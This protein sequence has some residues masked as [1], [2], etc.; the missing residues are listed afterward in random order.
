MFGFRDSKNYLSSIILTCTHK[1]IH[2][3]LDLLLYFG[4]LQTRD[5]K[6][7]GHT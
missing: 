1:I 3:N 5:R 2:S 7:P 6:M 4:L